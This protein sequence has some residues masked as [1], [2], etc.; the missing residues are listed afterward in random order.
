MRV[1]QFPGTPTTNPKRDAF[2]IT[3]ALRG[4]DVCHPLGR[5]EWFKPPYFSRVL[6]FWC[7]LP[8]LPWVSW[9]LWGWR[10][11]V[12]A[13]VF[14][15]DAAEYCHWLP[16]GDVYAGSMAIHFSARLSIGD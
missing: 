10:G 3:F 1:L 16:P 11:Y 15:A 14:G 6:R 9:R 4:G 2:G 8:V 12:G 13:K 7:P 5:G